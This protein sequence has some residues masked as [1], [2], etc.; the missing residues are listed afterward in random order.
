MLESNKAR[1]Y[2][3]EIWIL[4]MLIFV[5]FGLFVTKE[6][7]DRSEKEKNNDLYYSDSKIKKITLGKG[8][9]EVSLAVDKEERRKGLSGRESIRDNEGMFFIFPREGNY[10]FWMKDMKFPID[11]IWLSKDLR[12]VE[13][14]ENVQPESFPET[15]APKEK[16][17]Y[18][19]EL[20]AGSSKKY[21]IKLGDKVVFLKE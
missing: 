7:F 14:K 5:I 9:F 11:I 6:G 1:N 19:V 12:V 4:A 8:T 18:V 20:K 2:F 13:I 16:A 17:L 3:L 15:F 21:N 10:P